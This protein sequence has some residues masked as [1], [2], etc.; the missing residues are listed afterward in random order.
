MA[1]QAAQEQVAARHLRCRQ[2]SRQAMLQRCN[3]RRRAIDRVRSWV[4]VSVVSACGFAAAAQTHAAQEP[5][6]QTAAAHVPSLTTAQLAEFAR[7]Q[8]AAQKI[9]ASAEFQRP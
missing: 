9:L 3:S 2:M 5:H 6:P 7:A 1:G 4:L 8:T